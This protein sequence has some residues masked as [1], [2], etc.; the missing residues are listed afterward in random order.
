MVEG[1]APV[2]CAI[3]CSKWSSNKWRRTFSRSTFDSPE[4]GSK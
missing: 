4:G 2:V 1:D 3:H